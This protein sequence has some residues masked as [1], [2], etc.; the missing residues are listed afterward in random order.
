MNFKKR[1]CAVLLSVVL[2]LLAVLPSYASSQNWEISDF[3][4]YVLHGGDNGVYRTFNKGDEITMS[5]SFRYEYN[6]E[7]YTNRAAYMR[8]DDDIHMAPIAPITITL[9]RKGWWSPKKIGSF[10]VDAPELTGKYTMYTDFE[11]SLGIADKDSEEYYIVFTKNC[12]G[13]YTDFWKVSGSG[14]ISY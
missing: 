7:D 13:G 12:G 5:G 4:G 2:V 9:Y 11:G 6:M 8:Y 1:C 10:T 14:D 3:T